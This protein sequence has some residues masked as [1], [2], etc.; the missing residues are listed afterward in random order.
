MIVDPRTLMGGT[1][2]DRRESDSSEELEQIE[3]KR[4]PSDAADKENTG[5][6]S[7]SDSDS[8]TGSELRS[9]DQRR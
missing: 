7:A 2:P 8:A 6:T 5:A 1:F 4:R 3:K 9:I